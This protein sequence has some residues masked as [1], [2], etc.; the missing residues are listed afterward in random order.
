MNAN[1]MKKIVNEFKYDLKCYLCYVEVFFF[2][3]FYLRPSDLI[4][5]FTYYGQLLSLLYTF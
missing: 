2:F 3:F 4:T 1:I 5:I